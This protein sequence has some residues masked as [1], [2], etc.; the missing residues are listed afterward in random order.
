MVKATTIL[1]FIGPTIYLNL[2]FLLEITSQAQT[3]DCSGLVDVKSKVLIE[4]L[5][6]PGGHSV[7]TFQND[8]KNENFLVFDLLASDQGY[9][10]VSIQYS[11][12]GKAKV[13]WVRKG[14]YLGTYMSNY[15]EGTTLNF[16]SQPDQNATV[17]TSIHKWYN[18][19]YT[20]LD[21]NGTWVKVIAT[22]NGKD[23]S[24]WIEGKWLCPNPY[25]TCN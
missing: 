10:K 13:G 11:I 18:A 9:F 6:K 14:D 15:A 19:F 2:F 12:N 8:Q 22:L 24:G 7:G 5:D 21:C 23:Y 20:I 16:Y 4:I 17:S 25:S 3:C 1:K